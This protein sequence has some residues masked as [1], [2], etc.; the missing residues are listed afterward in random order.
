MRTDTLRRCGALLLGVALAGVLPGFAQYRE[1]LIRG[2]VVDTSKAPVAG[3]E[4]ILRDAATSRS[5]NMKTDKNGEFK[6][7]GLPHGVYKVVFK[8][9]GF[10]TKEDEWR[11]ESP[12]EKMEH[13]EIPPV[14]MASEAV[15]QEAERLKQAEAEIKQAA[16]KIRAGDYDGA[17]ALLGPFLD[18][19]P[20][21]ANA[22]YLSG[23]AYLKKKMWPEAETRLARVTEIIPNFPAAW[24]QYGVS[25]QQQG[26]PEEA[27]KCY[28]KASSLDPQNP[29]GLYNAGLVLFGLNRIDEALGHFEKALALKPDDP[30]IEEMAG[31]CYINQARFD[32]AVELLEKAKAGYAADP[33][34][35]KFLDELI[36]KVKEQIK[37]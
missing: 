26:R 29:D 37:K 30:A 20:S 12:Q 33:E 18:K 31:R 13:V 21:D 10:A 7:T 9:A 4:V 25:L 16:E 8:K 6:F 23:M 28:E 19:N 22:L 14:V 1:Y 11:F 3:V 5:Y 27:L 2:K 24:Y 17:L 34:R 36:A 32:K 35:V 15:V